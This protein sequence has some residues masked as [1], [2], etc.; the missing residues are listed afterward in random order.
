M[1][2][3]PLKFVTVDR[4]GEAFEL[5]A[6]EQRYQNIKNTLIHKKPQFN[7]WWATL[8]YS[9]LKQVHLFATSSDF[10][11]SFVEICKHHLS[12]LSITAFSIPLSKS[13]E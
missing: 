11:D 1:K 9:T 5:A 12:Q 6:K 3:S 4:V 10:S 7:F 8:S 2:K 13:L